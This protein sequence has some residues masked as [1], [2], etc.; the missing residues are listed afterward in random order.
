MDMWISVVPPG[1]AVGLVE[2]STGGL[3]PASVEVAIEV[4]NGYLWRLRLGVE[5][6]RPVVNRLD[7]ERASTVSGAYAGPPITATSLRDV[8][9][10]DMTRRAIEAAGRAAAHWS[11]RPESGDDAGVAAALARRRRP[12]T[13][14]LL[15]R[16]AQVARINPYDPRHQVAEQ[17]ST[18]ERSATRWIAEAKRRGFLEED[19]AIDE[20][21]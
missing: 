9:F 12:M 16:V 4:D 11:G 10:E 19:E 14:A 5:D 13:D 7:V 17:L 3:F 20:E 8:P 1:V 6:R 18:S 15:R 21:D 2:L